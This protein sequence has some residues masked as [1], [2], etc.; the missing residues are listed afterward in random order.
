MTTNESMST[1]NRIADEIKSLSPTNLRLKY[2][3]VFGE[4]PT[5]NSRPGLIKK[6]V[7]ALVERA[8]M[9]RARQAAAPARRRRGQPVTGAD[10]PAAPG[11]ASTGERGAHEASGERVAERDPRLPPPGTVIEKLDRR[12]AIRCKCTVLEHGIR[13]AGKEYRSLSAAAKAA[14]EDLGLKGAANAYLFWGLIRQAARKDATEILDKAGQRYLRSV[15]SL[16][17]CRASMTD[18]M[19]N[20]IKEMLARQG[21]RLAEAAREF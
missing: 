15:E 17:G 2:M 12:G 4:S 14:M 9:E 5:S 10:A 1:A 6:I 21:E 13:Y 3:E 20:R 7:K 19:K 18:E 8:E 16:N 11:D